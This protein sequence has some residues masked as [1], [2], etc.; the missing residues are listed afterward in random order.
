MDQKLLDNKI[1]EIVE[2]ELKYDSIHKEVIILTDKINVAHTERAKMQ[3]KE[4][5]VK[6]ELESAYSGM[7]EIILRGNK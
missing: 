7:K 5:E 1:K 3:N 2:L 4:E 6:N